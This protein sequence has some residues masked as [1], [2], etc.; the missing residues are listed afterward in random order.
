MAKSIF[1]IIGTLVLSTLL[2]G[3]FPSQTTAASQNW[4]DINYHFRRQI[5]ITTGENSPF[6]GY[7]GYTVEMMMDTVSP[8]IQD[9]GNDIRI[10]WWDGSDW[11]DLDRHIINPDT[12]S[13]IIRFRIQADIAVSSS[14]DNYYV[15]Y[16]NASAGT[17]PTNLDNVYRHYDDFSTDRSG[18][19]N[20]GRLGISNWHGSGDYS[21]PYDSINQR[22]SYDTGDN[23]VGE[24]VVTDINERDVYLE[25]KLSD[26]G[27]YPSNTTPGLLTRIQWGTPSSAINDFYGASF[28]QGSYNEA[29]IGR[30]AR[31]AL[32]S[33][34]DPAGTNYY[35]NNT[36]YRFYFAVWGINATNFKA[37]YVSDTGQLQWQPEV[38]PYV[39]SSSIEISDLE[40]SGR[41]GFLVAQQR[42]WIDE[43]MVRRYIEPE[44]A[45][46]IGSEEPVPVIAVT[47]GDATS[48]G[49]DSARLNGNLD[50]LGTATSVDISFEWDEAPGGPYL[51][52]TTPQTMSATG[53]FSFALN[54]LIPN[55]TYYFRVKGVGDSTI[56]GTEK[57]FTTPAPS[58]G[59]LPFVENDTEPIDYFLDINAQGFQKQF[60]TDVNG[61]LFETVDITLSDGT[62]N[63]R[64]P[65]RTV[66]S[67]QD[68]KRLK[69]L[70]IDLNE[71]IPIS[72]D[73]TYFIGPVCTLLPEGT[74]F[75]PSII[76]TWKYSPDNLPE[77]V[78]EEDLFPASYNTNTDEWT[79]LYGVVDTTNHTITTE[80]NNP[81]TLV[82][83]YVKPTLA[84]LNVNNPAKSPI[85]NVAGLNEQAV[86]QE[87]NAGPS[88]SPNSTYSPASNNSNWQL[89]II[90][91]SGAIAMGGIVSYFF[92]T[93]VRKPYK[94]GK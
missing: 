91:M 77:G 83:F 80:I 3:L 27:K 81:M 16:G 84:V 94:F 24:W 40:T 44:P 19:Y 33:A 49:V 31:N 25:I 28:S 86:V 90:I 8:D 15:Y 26:S 21:P 41:V 36:A 42:G 54:N 66:I 6:N 79:R 67:G 4:W 87:V 89:I 34:Y 53:A 47:S 61:R 30:N 74:T 68:H 75:N 5:T 11:Q 88:E 73:D 45:I 22:I 92:I 58:T 37:D 20:I 56:Y 38:T 35:A 76:L 71:I 72:S 29:G 51:I 2:I 69:A 82:V 1:H 52:E 55:T 59:T 7:T 63:I 14:D 48:V 62:L 12:T 10:V 64:I 93:K 70:D 9:D 50:D 60:R 39:N 46:V 78:N 43:V 18:E 23:Y 13:T 17:G 32:I 65:D 57:S 85:G